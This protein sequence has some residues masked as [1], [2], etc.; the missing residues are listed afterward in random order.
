MQAKSLVRLKVVLEVQEK[1]KEEEEEEVRLGPRLIVRYASSS[2][3]FSSVCYVLTKPLGA[4][5]QQAQTPANKKSL[6]AGGGGGGGG[7]E[8]ESKGDDDGEEGGR[9]AE[10]EVSAQASLAKL[11]EVNRYTKLAKLL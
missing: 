1:E 8:V 7:G 2:C 11:P 10:V 3:L 9:S 5:P 4:T 6:P